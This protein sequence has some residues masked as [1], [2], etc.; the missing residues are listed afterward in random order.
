MVEGFCGHSHPS[1]FTTA[2]SVGESFYPAEDLGKTQG[3][4]DLAQIFPWAGERGEEWFFEP[5]VRTKEGR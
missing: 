2:R 4:G 3:L 5:V 1:V